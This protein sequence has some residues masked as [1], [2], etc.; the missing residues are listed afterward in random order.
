M[1]SNIFLGA[2]CVTF[3]FTIAAYSPVGRLVANQTP[4]SHTLAASTVGEDST[5]P[6]YDLTKKP[7]PKGNRLVCVSQRRCRWCKKFQ[8]TTLPALVKEGYDVQYVME[9][10]WKG[11]EIK[12]APT[13]FFFLDKKIVYTHVGYMDAK[14]AKEYLLEPPKKK[15]KK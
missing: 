11:P 8:E 14:T 10:N 2:C 6:I 7:K 4:K 15:K 12:Y 9:W 1:K 3:A 5:P 13:L